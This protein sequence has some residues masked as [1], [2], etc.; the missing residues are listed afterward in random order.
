VIFEELISVKGIGAAIGMFSFIEIASILLIE[1]KSIRKAPQ[2]SINLLLGIKTGKI[3]LT[4]LF[5]AVYAFAVKVE[6]QRFFM[7]FLVLYLIYLFSNTIY[8]TRREKVNG[9]S[10]K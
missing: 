3:F 5:I 4:L 7:V 10:Y 2:K 8:I 1:K 9:K 6:L